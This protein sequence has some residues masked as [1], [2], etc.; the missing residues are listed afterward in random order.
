MTGSRGDKTRV[1]LPS[2]TFGTTR[3]T[4]VRRSDLKVA[5]DSVSV[6]TVIISPLPYAVTKLCEYPF[7]YRRRN[8]VV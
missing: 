1:K 6:E 5:L 7:K 4:V 3:E 8:S 2:R